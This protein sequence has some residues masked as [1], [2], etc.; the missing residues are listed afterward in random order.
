VR[1]KDG[2]RIITDGPFAEAKEQ[3]GGY[4]LVE[5]EDLDQALGIAA[6][7]PGVRFGDVVEIRPVAPTSEAARIPPAR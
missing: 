4:Y 1:E 2:E 5:C 3:L 7:I 6:R